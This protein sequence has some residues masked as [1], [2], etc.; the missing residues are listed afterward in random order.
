MFLIFSLLGLL[1]DIGSKLS[2]LNIQDS[3]NLTDSIDWG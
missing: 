1:H 2:T 3:W